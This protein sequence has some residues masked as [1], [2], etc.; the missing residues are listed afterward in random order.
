M[1]N[2]SR[3]MIVSLVLLASRSA[4]A[5]ILRGM[6]NPRY[7]SKSVHDSTERMIRQRVFFHQAVGKNGCRHVCLSARVR[8]ILLTQLVI[9]AI[10][11]V[12]SLRPDGLNHGKRGAV[13][14]TISIVNFKGGVGKTTLSVNLAACLALEHRK[15]VLLIDLDPQSNS[16]VWML[17]RQKWQSVN[18]RDNLK[19]TAYSLFFGTFR[20]D[21]LLQPYDDPM[22]KGF[23]PGLRLLPA[24]FHM[25]R[26]EESMMKKTTMQLIAGKYKKGDEYLFLDKK[27]PKIAKKFD[28]V[29]LDCA[30]NLYGATKNAIWNSDH[31]LIPCVPDSLSTMGL[32]QLIH[33]L[34]DIAMDLKERT[35]QNKTPE[36]LGVAVIRMKPSV[37]EHKSGLAQM[38]KTVTTLR[39]GKSRIV[40]KKSAVFADYPLRDLVK[41]SE[42]VE[43]SKPLCLYAPTSQAYGD[44]KALTQAIKDAAV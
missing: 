15:K 31:I 36:L 35:G 9:R 17:G 40:T 7:R 19:K 26:L 13:G 37:N 33:Q 1:Q 44:V 8:L 29:I 14:T 5:L 3:Q 11:R 22:K 30:P 23:I 27:I 21:Y 43:E 10:F 4:F 16:S 24:S 28:Y 32:K 6:I 20:E 42:A 39:N 38:T 12:G 18:T 25:I 2:T 41:H 34:D